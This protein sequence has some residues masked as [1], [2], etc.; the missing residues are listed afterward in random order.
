LLTGSCVYAL[1]GIAGGAATISRV[2]YY[3]L[4]ASASV[5]FPLA[6]SAAMLSRNVGGAPHPMTNRF[7]WLR[8]TVTAWG[9]SLAVTP[10]AAAAVIALDRVFRGT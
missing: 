2:L 8:P 7:G 1:S 4:V 6:V 5:A 9:A 10:I 3:V